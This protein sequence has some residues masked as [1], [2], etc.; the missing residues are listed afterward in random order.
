MKLFQ[1]KATR[2]EQEGLF[3]IYHSRLFKF[4]ADKAQCP[5]LRTFMRTV[6]VLRRSVIQKDVS[7]F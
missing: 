1:G 2:L 4:E 6:L 3:L 5:R 7:F